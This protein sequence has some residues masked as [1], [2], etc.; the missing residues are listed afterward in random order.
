MK[1]FR[2]LGPVHTE[3]GED[4]LTDLATRTYQGVHGP[5]CARGFTDLRFP[6]VLRDY[7]VTAIRKAY[8][9]FDEMMQTW[10]QLNGSVY[11]LERYSTDAVKAVPDES[12]AFPHRDYDLLFCSFLIY[13]PNETIDQV[14]ADYGKRMRQHIVDGSDE[15]TRLNVYVNYAHGDEQ[16]LSMYG[17][18]DWRLEKLR[19]LKRKYD[20]Q[21]VL[22]WYAPIIPT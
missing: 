7:N 6:T 19:M 18:E 3:K 11:L 10:P 2:T 22:R 17:W 13:K 14:A 8:D 21:N 1:P 4:V 9:D 16:L 5:G 15:P 20:P 12:T